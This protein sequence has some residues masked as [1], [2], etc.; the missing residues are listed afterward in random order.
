M[1]V[2]HGVP[3]GGASAIPLSAGSILAVQAGTRPDGSEIYEAPYPV[4]VAEEVYAVPVAV[5]TGLGAVAVGAGL[6]ALVA[7]EDEQQPKKRK[8]GERSA[9][10]ISHFEQ[11]EK[12]YGLLRS[13]REREGHANVPRTKLEGGEYLGTW[14]AHQRTRYK[15][16]TASDEE[17]KKAQRTV[18]SDE[19]VARL[20]AL[21]VTW[22]VVLPNQRDN[23]MD[24]LRAFHEREGHGNA[25]RAHIEGGEKLG[26]WLVKQRQ[27]YHLRKMSEAEKKEKKIQR[28]VMTDEE[29]AALE[30]LGV[31]WFGR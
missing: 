23:M 28:S 16:R 11:Q 14:L 27:R 4:A 19:E 10:G 17:R 21:D 29:K 8:K 18:M 15:L 30:T 31:T 26:V 9:K 25:P 24:L 22:E 7:N 3:H 5:E 2:V 20:E 1:L 13:F 12:M 6:S